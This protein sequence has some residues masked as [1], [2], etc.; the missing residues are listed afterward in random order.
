MDVVLDAL[1]GEFVD[2][3]LGLVADAGRF[4]EMGKADIRDPAEVAARWPEVS[5]QAFDLMDAGPQ[6]LG[7]I[8]AEVLGLFARGVL[9]GLPVRAWGVD[10]VT[11]ALRF[12]GQ[13]RHAGKNVVRMPVPLDRS[14]TVLVTGGTGTLGGLVARHLAG[15]GQAGQPG[16]GLAPRPGRRR[17]RPRWPPALAAAGSAG[18]GRRLRYRGPAG[19]GRAARADP[20][21]VPADR[22]DPHGGRAG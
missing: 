22:G 21:R 4:I 13:G 10:Q 9:A 1:A 16:A 17:A 14:G 7:E 11:Q 12:M 6:R 2:A 20:G 15:T 19:P 5:Y 18:T 8:L 3:S